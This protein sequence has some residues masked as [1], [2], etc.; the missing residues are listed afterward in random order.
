[1]SIAGRSFMIN[2]SFLE[3]IDAQHIMEKLPRLKKPLLIMHSPQDEIVGIANAAELYSS[4]W[5]PKSFISLDG[6]DHLL[7]GKAD[8]DGVQFR[9]DHGDGEIAFQIPVA[10]VAHDG[11]GVAGSHAQF[12]SG[13][14]YILHD[15][16][17]DTI[18]LIA[19]LAHQGSPEV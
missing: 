6:V 15:F 10:V 14:H 7:R 4:A 8:V 3:D 17:L 5:H 13:R 16:H 2:S 18:P 11:H 12:A 1:M 19:L 9:A